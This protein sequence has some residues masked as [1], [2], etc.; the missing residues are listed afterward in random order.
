MEIY[1]RYFLFHFFVKSLLKPC[2]S[3]FV[4][5]TDVTFNYSLTTIRLNSINLSDPFWIDIS[6]NLDVQEREA[7]ERCIKSVESTPALLK[8]P[9][10]VNNL[11]S[12]LKHFTD[13]K[14]LLAINNFEGVDIQPTIEFPVILRNL[15]LAVGQLIYFHPSYNKTQHK[16]NT[17]WTQKVRISKLN[18]NFS[19]S[20]P[21]DIY[22][23]SFY[24]NCRLFPY[25]YSLCVRCQKC[26]MFG[27]KRAQLYSVIKAVAILD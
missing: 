24:N 2:H 23:F 15:D 20:W 27:P 16:T 9:K 22:N 11:Y 7:L 21:H 4:N 5:N 8:L 6:V 18:G 25:I 14:C 19:K 26:S 10:V 13:D 3:T 17:F 1:A 12:T